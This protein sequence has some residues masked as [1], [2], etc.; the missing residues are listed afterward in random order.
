MKDVRLGR[1]MRVV[2]MLCLVFGCGVEKTGA[3]QSSLTPSQQTKSAKPEV[4]T[5]ITTA[6]GIRMA[7]VPAGE[8]R[9]GNESGEEDERP[10]HTV[11]IGAF[12]MDVYEVTQRSYETLMGTNPSKHKDPRQPVEQLGWLAA[13]KYCNMRS[14]K[15]GLKPCYTL[16]TLACDFAADGYRL[17]TEAEWEYACRAGSTG[18]FSFSGGESKLGEAGWYKANAGDSTHPAGEK[19]PNAWGLYDMHGNV[20]EWCM[21]VYAEDYFAHSPSENPCNTGPGDERVLR[22][23]G[24][25]SAP[26]LCRASARYSEAPGLADVCFGYDAYGFRCV[27]RA[28]APAN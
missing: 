18:D 19:Q 27:K 15:E 2:A 25:N 11:K 24:W 7:A 13:I 23:G 4:G 28:T 16:D 20:F 6:T 3:P 1:T 9:M 21:D 17:P 26:D 5:A 22:G 8:F 14:L 12:Y 10:A